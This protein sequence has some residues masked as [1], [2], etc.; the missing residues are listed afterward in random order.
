MTGM[1]RGLAMQNELPIGEANRWLADSEQRVVL[2]SVMG[3]EVAK[4]KALAGI[5]HFIGKGEREAA[6]TVPHVGVRMPGGLPDLLDQGMA[7]GPL[8][9]VTDRW[10]SVNDFK[11]SA[12][13]NRC[14]LHCLSIQPI[15]NWFSIFF[16]LNQICKL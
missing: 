12:S 15:K 1:K 2:T 5:S 16:K 6:A 10:A 14:G 11:P 13:L 7:S 9:R 3:K 4:A 8:S